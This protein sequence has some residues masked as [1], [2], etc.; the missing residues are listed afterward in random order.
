M[1]T[2]QGLTMTETNLAGFRA[3]VADDNPINL[4]IID[5]FLRRLGLATTLV[6]NGR[7]AVNAWAPG[8]FDILCLD[9]SMPELT[10]IEVLRDIRQRAKASGSPMPPVVAITANAM[11]AQVSEYLAAGFDGCIA[12]PVRRLQIGEEL[13]R[14]LGRSAAPAAAE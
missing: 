5:S 3:L 2:A 7:Q 6:E 8:R 11:P 12:K 13:S 14:L 4:Q 9:I 10:G 1:T